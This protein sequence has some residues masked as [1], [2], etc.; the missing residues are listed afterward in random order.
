MKKNDKLFLIIAAVLAA[1]LGC[2]AFVKSCKTISQNITTCYEMRNDKMSLVRGVREGLYKDGDYEC[3]KRNA[4]MIE[5]FPYGC[6]DK[7]NDK[8]I[9][10]Y[11][12]KDDRL[13]KVTW[14]NRDRE[15]KR[16][17]YFSVY[18]TY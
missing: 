7:N 17:E 8:G 14:Y 6:V 9:R 11:M 13:I 1:I 18:S 15:I 16:T 10:D 12:I 2:F 4:F 3:I 5:L